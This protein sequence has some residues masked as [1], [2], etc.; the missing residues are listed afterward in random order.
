MKV[1]C[2]N[3]WLSRS[4]Y[5]LLQQ[6]TYQDYQCF[7]PLLTSVVHVRSI[8]GTCIHSKISA[9]YFEFWRLHVSSEVKLYI[10][11][12]DL[13]VQSRQKNL[14]D[15]VSFENQK[16]LPKTTYVINLMWSFW[17]NVFWNC[18]CG[19]IYTKEEMWCK[20]TFQLLIDF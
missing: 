12:E 2:M 13:A 9:P 5:I 14:K 15:F 1:E 3:D 17:P 11:K 20:Y 16:N 7:C 18:F 19:N 10:S 8:V 4:S 6:S